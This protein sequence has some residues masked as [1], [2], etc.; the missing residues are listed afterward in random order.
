M[1]SPA[2]SGALPEIR[3]VDAPDPAE[4]RCLVDTCPDATFFHDRAWVELYVRHHGGRILH[5]VAHADGRLVGGMIAVRVKRGVFHAIESL[6][7]GTYGGPLVS[8]DFRDADTLRAALVERFLQLGRR[9]TCVRV[10]C[11]LRRGPELPGFTTAPIHVIPVDLGFE[12]FWL[13]VFPRNRRNECNRAEK[14]NVEVRIGMSDAELDAFYPLHLDAHARWAMRPHPIG[15]FAELRGIPDVR[16]FTVLHEDTVLGAHFSL[17][18][19]DELLMW[20]GVTR[21]E[22]SKTYF[23]SSMLVKRQAE[24]AVRLGLA[25]LNLGGS[26]GLAGIENFKKLVGGES[27]DTCV[28]EHNA[29]PARVWHRVRHRGMSRGL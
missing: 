2:A 1:A 16:V 18:S 10:Q 21:R 27:A 8:P 15:F 17:L 19:Q 24:E 7:L 28:L 20:H 22:G 13:K 29:W 4:W 26:G 25:R 14:R 5:L 3:I 9:G 6:P 23:P 12:H 11:V